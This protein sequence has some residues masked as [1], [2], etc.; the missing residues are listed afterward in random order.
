MS[1]SNNKKA[2]VI[3]LPTNNESL[4]SVCC[5]RSDKP[6]LMSEQN[7]PFKAKIYDTK[8]L[9]HTYFNLYIISD[10]EIKEGDWCITGLKIIRKCKSILYSNNNFKS[11]N[12]Y[13]FEDG[14]KDTRSS[15][16]KIIATTDIS[17][18]ISNKIICDYCGGSGS[19][20]SP[21]CKRC[22]G[23]GKIFNFI[24]LPQLSQQ[25][26]KKH[27]ES[28]NA[29]QVISD[30]LVEYINQ[31]SDDGSFSVI[32]N[33]V[34]V[35]QVLKINPKD[36]TITIKR[37]KNSWNREEVIILIKLLEKDIKTARSLYD[38]QGLDKWIEQNL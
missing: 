20:F 22:K 2:K 38:N 36:N 16:K 9:Y 29:G 12:G 6:F 19:R 33:P 23:T 15:C 37:L 13:E 18:E 25:F 31:Y 5:I 21:N 35:N 11:I 7:S 14:T 24:K 27:I 10:D 4:N 32:N 3:M 8:D 34:K 28:Y 30:V 26:I 17:L 1:T